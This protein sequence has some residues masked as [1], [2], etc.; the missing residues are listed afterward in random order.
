MTTEP[1][2]KIDTLCVHAGI[3]PEPITGAV[4]TPIFQTST[5]VQQGPGEHSGYEYSRSGNPTRTVLESS[6][7]ALEGVRHAI[8]FASGLAA[9]QALIQT[10]DPGEHVIVSEDVY[11]GTGRL[12]RRLF[13][14]YGIDF[15]FLDLRDLQR[16]EASLKPRTKLIWIETPTNPMLHIIDVRA[17]AQIAKRVG[18]KV[19]V[20]NTFCSPVLQRPFELGADLAVHSTTKYIGGHSDLV[21]GVLMTDDDP[22]AEQLR[23]I[24]FA[25]GAVN[26]PQECF[27]LLRSIKTLALRMERHSANGLAL[28]QALERCGHFE[29]VIYP[30]L[31]SHPQHE[32]AARQMK[33]F[34][35]IVT[36]SLPGGLE[37][38]TRFLTSLKIFKLAESLGG[39]ESL[40]NHPQ[41]MTHASVP[42]E[43]RVKLGIDE[44]LIRFSVGIEDSGDLIE[45]VLQALR[46]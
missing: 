31:A 45:D 3:E 5:Y 19:L 1:H 6:L 14:K 10:L 2:H 8:T 16:L 24:Q 35:G 26:A 44:H 12:F 20:D 30:G 18:A 28:A 22:I 37:R 46:A 4:M 39:V 40:V 27:L 34:S 42:P 15:D 38:V 13:A 23:F 17:V 33:G 41:L 36:V 32:L 43:L 21:G 11:G 25:A 9:E 7:A 29:K